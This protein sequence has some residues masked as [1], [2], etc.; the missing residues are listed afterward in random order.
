MFFVEAQVELLQVA[1]SGADVGHFV[2]G[3][4]F[5]K[6]GAACQDEHEREE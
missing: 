4:G 5:A 6:Y 1:Y 2:D 3:D